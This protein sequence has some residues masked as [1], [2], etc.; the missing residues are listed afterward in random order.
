MSELDFIQYFTANANQFMWFLGAG[1]SRTAGMPTAMDLIWDLKVKYYCREE[2]QDIKNHDINNEVV[3]KRVQ[4]YMD[5]KNFPKLWSP[6]EYSFYFELTFGTDY[7]AQQK[8]LLEQLHRDKISLNIGHRALAGLVALKKSRLIFTT[9]FDEVN[10][11]ACAKV[12]GISIS[13]FNLEGSYAALDALNADQFPIYAKIHGDFKFRSVKNL[14]SDLISNDEKIQRCFIAAATRFGL[15]LSGYSGRD[16]NVMSMFREAVTQNNAFPAGI[17]WTVTDIKRVEPAISDFILFAQSKGINAHIIETGTFDSTLSKIWR[18]LTDK[19]DELNKQVNTASAL[20]VKIPMGSKGTGFPVIRT[21]ALEIKS[22]PQQCAVVSTTSQLTT[23]EVKEL[24]SRNKAGSIIARAD[25]IVAWGEIAEIKKGLGEDKIVEIRN[26]VIENPCNMITISTSYHSF[27]ERALA[28]ALCDGRPISLKND[29]GFVLAVNPSQAGNAIFQPLKD[30]LADNQGRPGY[31]TGFVPNAVQG[32]VWS[33]AVRIKIEIRN[34]NAYILL[35][36]TT[37]IEPVVE[38]QNV[39]EFIKGKRKYRYN[40]KA[41][42]VLDAWITILFGS[43]GKGEVEVVF[44]K[45]AEYPA[46]FKI[47]TRTSYSRK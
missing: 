27:F 25:N 10:E 30:A 36:P 39:Q 42:R 2:N 43:V 40:P 1:T 5:S 47:N 38:R 28:V 34:N 46:V 9:N 35:K 13:T 7:S 15:V 3:K 23:Q 41:F 29:F 12:A 19:S 8:Y 32:T 4:S 24:L 22:L 37:W 26:H 44:Q 6:E 31:I 21:N 16:N 45:E 20:E 11:V 17:F 18:Q 33:E 14:S